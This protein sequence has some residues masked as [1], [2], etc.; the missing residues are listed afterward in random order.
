ME[1]FKSLRTLIWNNVSVLIQMTAV[2][3]LDNMI[4]IMCFSFTV[5]SAVTKRHCFM[6]PPRKSKK[7]IRL[8]I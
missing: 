8:H 6:R 4:H 2:I 1:M 3:H 7:Q 5:T